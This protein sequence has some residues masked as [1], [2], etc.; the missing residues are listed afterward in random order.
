MSK[1]TFCNLAAV[2][3]L[4]FAAPAHTDE[5]GVDVVFTDGEASII[6]AYYQGQVVQQKGKK[7]DSKGLPPGIA[8][9]L[10][11]GK[12]LPPGIAKQRLPAGLLG[13]LPPPPNGYER[14][15]LSGKVLLVE[16]ATQIIHDVLD[17]MIIGK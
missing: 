13:Q 12:P 14:I 2:M 11:R 17:E 9:N 10:K 5:I 8:K 3:M 4:A 1:S 16:I 6:R 15:E 7:K